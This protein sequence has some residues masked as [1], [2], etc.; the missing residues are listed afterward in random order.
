MIY[1]RIEQVRTS[2]EIERQIESLILEGVLRS[3]DKLPGE[4]EL[5]KSFNV[6]RPIVREALS[7]LEERQL[8]IARHGGGTYVADVIGTVFAAPVIRLIGSN[9]K[10]KSDYLE[11][12]NEVEA[13][14]ASMAARRATNAD[15]QLLERI[16]D[17]M[18][19][20]HKE[21]NPQREASVD[22][23]FH[24]AIGECAHNIILLHT[25]RSCYRL[26]SDDVFYNREKIYGGPGT[27][28]TLL[29]QH[30][31]IYNAVMAGDPEAAA[32]AS[33]TH[34]Q[35]IMQATREVEQKV[36]WSVVSELRL[37]QRDDRQKTGKS[38]RK[39]P[40]K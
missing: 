27:R 3:G 15:R 7:A 36:D 5:S 18:Q 33:Q 29:Q 2:R 22:V 21:A 37:A 28:E 4:R 8:L 38:G 16:M 9:A 14:S 17:D 34:I 23:E 32:A 35:Y 1:R 12:R 30:L 11:Y 31:D 40:A 20:A 26:L 39:K 24:S 6:S 19:S 10:A 25:L 13:I